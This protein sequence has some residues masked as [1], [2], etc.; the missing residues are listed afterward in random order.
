V[1]AGFRGLVQSMMSSGSGS[2][3][4]AAG[5]SPPNP[6]GSRGGPAH[7]EAVKRR[8]KEL[9][10]EGHE[11][12]A[13]GSKL[14]EVIETRGGS[15]SSRRPDITTRAPDGSIYRENVGRST[16]KGEPVA[17]ERRALDDVEA[18]TGQ[19]PGYTAYDR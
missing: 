10:A 11:H 3:G 6:H 18:K 17:R 2:S 7:Q 16:A 12:L 4:P 19:R 9:E 15:K 1:A 13:G 14:E 8:I 5:R